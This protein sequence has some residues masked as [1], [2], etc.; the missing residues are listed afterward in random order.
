M[1]V[2]QVEPQN[3]TNTQ[4]RAVDQPLVCMYVYIYI[5]IFWKH[6]SKPILYTGGTDFLQFGN[7]GVDEIFFSRKEGIGLKGRIANRQKYFQCLG[8]FLIFFFKYKI[9]APFS[10]VEAKMHIFNI[11]IGQLSQECSVQTKFLNFLFS[12]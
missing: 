12:K 7:K 1:V 8:N 3:S 6:S 11:H 10:L 2:P 5:Y 9:S 4:V